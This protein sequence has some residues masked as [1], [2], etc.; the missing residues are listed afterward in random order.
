MER[1]PLATVLAMLAAAAACDT[2]EPTAPPIAHP[3]PTAAVTASATV[4]GRVTVDEPQDVGLFTS[5]VSSSDGTQRVTYVDA[6]NDRLKYAACASS[7]TVAGNWQRGVI[8]QSVD[9]D[10]YTSLKVKSGVRH[11]VYYDRTNG[12]L[13]YASCASDCYLE[14]N[15]KKVTI[16]QT[17]DVGKFAS[18]AIGGNGRLHV[19]YADATNYGLRYATCL[20]SCT[21]AIYWR[22]TTAVSGISVVGYTSTAVGGDGRVHVAFHNHGALRYATCPASC[23]NPANWE[24][25]A[26]EGNGAALNVGIG[27]DIAIDGNGVRH[28]TYHEV[29][30]ENLRYARCASNCSNSAGWQR[31]VVDIGSGYYGSNVGSHTSVAVGSDGKVHVSYADV[32]AGRLKYASCARYC[33]LTSSW[34]RQ[35]VDGGGVI[36]GSGSFAGRYTSLALGGG[37]VHVSY[38]NHTYGNLRYAELTQ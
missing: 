28:I 4:L 36:V 17:G 21:S 1:A 9:V 29:T 26:V 14:N 35:S 25:L 3:V 30:D 37:K 11:V 6:S 16:D 24:G 13:K 27:A 2:D 5:I 18:L 7:C 10:S 19:S 33:W 22:R 38:Y 31:V 12:N 20:V 34:Q 15:W 8:D 32:T 23:S